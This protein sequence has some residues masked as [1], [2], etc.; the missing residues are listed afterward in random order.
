MAKFRTID[1][2]GRVP[3]AYSIEFLGAEM[4]EEYYVPFAIIRY[5]LQGVEQEDGFRLDLD[6]QVFLDDYFED[7]KKNE[8]IKKVAPKIAKLVGAVLSSE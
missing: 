6:K 2:K 1:L 4:S 7:K 5:S 3:G 8:F